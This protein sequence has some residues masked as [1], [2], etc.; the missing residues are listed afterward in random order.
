MLLK[1][2]FL[3]LLLLV[4]V[5]ASCKNSASNTQ[6]EE[7]D[8]VQQ[9]KMDG[10]KNL[11]GSYTDTIPC[12]DCDGIV[13]SIYFKPDTTFILEQ[14]YIG[15]KKKN[16]V[17]HLGT[18]LLDDS[19]ITLNKTVDELQGVRLAGN[20]AEIELIMRN[21]AT[22]PK[23]DYTLL[24]ETAPFKPKKTVP[25]QGMFD[26][27]GDTMHLLVCET[28]KRYPAAI[29]AEVGGMLGNYQKIKKQDFE[30]VLAEVEG[31]FELRPEPG[32]THTKDF[33]VIK[34]FRRFLPKKGCETR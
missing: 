18:W 13:T 30:A 9:E 21:P 1:N 29:D 34:K 6:A 7:T 28:Q 4:F 23:F 2:N 14:Q 20:V 31:N 10:Y 15:S 3:F 27:K 32:G 25:L 12:E 16:I 11:I 26:A 8:P 33:F 24:K 22:H 5:L 17:Y 19:S